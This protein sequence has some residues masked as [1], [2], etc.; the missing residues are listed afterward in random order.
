MTKPMIVLDMDGVI[1]DWITPIN[2]I[3]C[4][5]GGD[6]YNIEWLNKCPYRNTVLDRI[7]KE[8]PNLFQ[9]LPFIEEADELLTFLEAG[10][11]NGMFNL[12]VA[13][14]TVSG[15]KYISH[16]DVREDKVEWINT[17]I[18]PVWPHLIQ[19]DG[20]VVAFTGE[21]IDNKSILARNNTILIDDY[22]RNVS[23]FEKNGGKAILVDRYYSSKG[24][25]EKLK[26]YLIE[27]GGE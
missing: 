20:Q 25:I 6:E 14:H 10:V 5:H 24:V 8:H 4:T 19:H 7:Y 15:M 17:Y 13:T 18:K 21:G 11:K 16:E 23:E 9:N 27:M 2:T 26:E 22:H 12:I 3:L 1:A